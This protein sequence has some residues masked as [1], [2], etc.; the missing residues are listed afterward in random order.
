MA[1]AIM[2]K[3]QDLTYMTRLV[4]LIMLFL[5]LWL[6]IYLFTFKSVFDNFNFTI[7]FVI[8]YSLAL[9]LLDLHKTITYVECVCTMY[10]MCVFLSIFSQQTYSAANFHLK[11]PFN[12]TGFTVLIIVVKAH[13][14][15][16]CLTS[17]GVLG[18]PFLLYC[19]M[20]D[21]TELNYIQGEI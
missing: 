6:H 8:L 9:S 16:I 11:P 19:P 18:F 4:I 10:T 3:Q 7:S 5:G 17:Q 1:T 20:R 15:S 21:P 14:I 12:S 13:I 2:T